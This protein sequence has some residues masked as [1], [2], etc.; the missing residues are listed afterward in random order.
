MIEACYEKNSSLHISSAKFPNDLF[1]QK[2][3]FIQPNFRMTFFTQSL[4]HRQP[5]ITA[6][7]V[8]Y[9]L[10]QTLVSFPQ[11]SYSGL[12]GEGPSILRDPPQRKPGD[13]MN[14]F[15]TAFQKDS[16]SQS[17]RRGR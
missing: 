9:T 8:H 12:S 11:E 17:E 2:K 7:F 6:H 10:K 3:L 16:F 13:G 5:F 1:Y 14:K 15:S 4:L